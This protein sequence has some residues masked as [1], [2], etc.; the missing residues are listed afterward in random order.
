M[1]DRDKR[2]QSALDD[3]EAEKYRDALLSMISLYREG[4]Q[5][6]QI[7]DI[8]EEACFLPNAEEMQYNYQENIKALRKYPFVLGKGFCEFEELPFQLYI[9]SETEFYVF[10]K[11]E[12]RF[13]ELYQFDDGKPFDLYAKSLNS[14]LFLE[15][16]K[17]ISHLRYLN[18]N[19]RKSEDL[20][21]DNHIY[22][23]YSTF[24]ELAKLLVATQL[25]GLL[26]DQKFVFLFGEENRC[27]PID[28]KTKFGIDYGSYAPKRLSVEDIK[29]II[30]GWKIENVAGNTFLA[31]IM[32]FHPNLITI[33][34]LMMSSFVNFYNEQ[35]RGE[36]VLS[37]I[38]KLKGLPDQASQKDF[39]R[40]LVHVEDK[41]KSK[42]I[43]REL[44]RVTANQFLSVLEDVL[45]DIV[46]PKASEWLIGIYLAFSY[47][48]KREFDQR[49]IPALFVYPH[50]DIFYLAGIQRESLNFYFDLI[51]EFPYH[52]IISLIRDPVTQAGAVTN[53]MTKGHENAHNAN[54]EIQ[55]DPFYCMVFG[56]I[57]PKDFYFLLE[58]PL[59]QDIGV[60]R[61]EDLKLN[62]EATF[63]SMAEFLNLP[64]TESMY[65]TTECGLSA[66]GVNGEGKT[67]PGFDPAPVFKEYQQYLSVFDKYRI[68]L[69]L[70]QLYEAY[71]YKAKYYDGQ[72]F[73]DQE[74]AALMEL[75]FLCESIPTVVPPQQKRQLRNTAMSFIR[76]AMAI[77][78]VPF[79]VNG[80][81]GHFC[82]LR[83]LRPKEDKLREPL[84]E[85]IP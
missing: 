13:T 70:S 83:W 15:N 37:V 10:Q 74:V 23:F 82:P 19:I 51:Q 66:N 73:S 60:V 54:G 46:Y 43:L 2:F 38:T 50:D 6:T 69:L 24:E 32:D 65:Q 53:F 31:G 7:L 57:L 47:C 64:V 35:L 28:F 80:L 1:N 62:P 79:C 56:T 67:F 63:A 30:F 16:E 78:A 4:Y 45:S 72:I 44:N 85:R 27:C 41:R 20:A 12:K 36:S 22:L 39:I 71:G 40:K 49:F 29:R 11:K 17:N 55:M 59:Y 25:D 84:Y 52:K 33:P 61:F 58:H 21:Y 5:E 3:F 14:I 81:N 18:D 8:L 48:H 75:P 26:T 76:F 77:K 42:H 68:E 34:E 9:I